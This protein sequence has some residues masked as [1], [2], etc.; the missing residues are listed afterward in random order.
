M[1]RLVSLAQTG[2][3]FPVEQE[4]TIGSEGKW[5]TERLDKTR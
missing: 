5:P 2:L 4:R 3:Q 1:K